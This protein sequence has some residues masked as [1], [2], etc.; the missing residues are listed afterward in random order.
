MFDAEYGVNRKKQRRAVHTGLRHQ[1][2]QRPIA[3]LGQVA[4]QR[5]RIVSRVQDHF[6]AVPLGRFDVERR[7]V[8]IVFPGA[9]ERRIPA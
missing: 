1:I 8:V 2:E 6:V 9:D 3:K 5:E 7:L 4:R